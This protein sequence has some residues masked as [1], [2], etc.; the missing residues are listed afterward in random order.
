VHNIVKGQTGRHFVTVDLGLVL[1]RSNK[2][3]YPTEVPMGLRTH[4]IC[5]CETFLGAKAGLMK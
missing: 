5:S 4:T 2:L 1:C 3:P